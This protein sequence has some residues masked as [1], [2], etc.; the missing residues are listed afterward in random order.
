M[1]RYKDIW[2]FK[3]YAN[4]AQS[5]ATSKNTIRGLE[6]RV[7]DGFSTGHTPYG[8]DSIPTKSQTVK[9]IEKPSHFQPRINEPQA[10]IIRRIWQAFADGH[11]P[12]IIARSLNEDGVL[13]PDRKRESQRWSERTIKKMLEQKKYLGRWEYRKTKVVKDPIRNRLTQQ[14]RPKEEWLV[15][16]M[17]HLRIISP[18][19]E[20]RVG[21]RKE[22]ISRK[23]KVYGNLTRMDNTS[24]HLFVGSVTCHECGG[25]FVVVSG[26]GY[27]GCFNAHRETTVSCKNSQT[28]NMA[29]LEE[30]LLD[31]FWKIIEK[32]EVYKLLATRYNQLMAKKHGDAPARIEELDHLIAGVEKSIAN[33]VKFIADGNASEFVVK[34]LKESEGKLMLHKKEREY[35]AAQLNETIYV[36]PSAV[37]KKLSELPQLLA[38]KTVL[39]NQI[40]KNLV[41]GKIKLTPTEV[42]GRKTYLAEGV[43]NFH[44]VMQNA[45]TGEL[46]TVPFA[47]GARLR[48]RAWPWGN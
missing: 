20:K 15:T 39:A 21:D 45:L 1:R 26:K 3:G 12:K 30:S 7:I 5:K 14:P 32:E 6:V 43:L 10:A 42:A 9:G 11:G 31:E 8:Y 13:P 4:E 29:T 22:E 2:V 33:F 35:L 19:L 36:T 17:P 37:K 18:E 27:M 28:I 48:R 41:P 47:P 24:K 38:Q 44:S 46:Q 23:G 16:E 25:N 34:G 40:I